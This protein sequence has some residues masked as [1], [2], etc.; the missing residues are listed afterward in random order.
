MPDFN[1]T[2]LETQLRRFLYIGKEKPEY[3]PGNWF[4]H[5]YYQTANLSSI[6]ELASDPLKHDVIISIIIEVKFFLFF[7]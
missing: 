3:H 4:V 6:D 1:D 2:A 5:N 7:V